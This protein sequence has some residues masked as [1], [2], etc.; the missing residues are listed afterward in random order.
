MDEDEFEQLRRNFNRS[1]PKKPKFQR[2]PAGDPSDVDGYLGPWAGSVQDHV[3]EVSGPTDVR[4]A[5]NS[6][7]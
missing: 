5:L 7:F 3:G 4:S 2:K 6:H 1:K